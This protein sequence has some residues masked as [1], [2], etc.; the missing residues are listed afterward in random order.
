MKQ[1]HYKISNLSPIV[2]LSY[3]KEYN[4]YIQL[5]YLN[6]NLLGAKIITS[7]HKIGLDSHVRKAK[8][9]SKRKNYI[10]VNQLENISNLKAH[11]F[12]TANS[13]IANFHKI[14]YFVTGVGSGGTIRGVGRRLTQRL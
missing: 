8:E 9:L 13:M 3:F 6:F 12:G 1:E 10:Y 5:E 4:V 14:D 11:Y 2:K 7:N